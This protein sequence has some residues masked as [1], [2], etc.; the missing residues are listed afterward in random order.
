MLSLGSGFRITQK[1]PVGIAPALPLLGLVMQFDTETGVTD[2][3]GTVTAWADQATAS[4]DLVA[5]GTP[6]LVTNTLNG[7]S[8]ISFDGVGDSLIRTASVTGL[9]SGNANRTM[10]SVVK[11]DS[12]GYGGAAYGVGDNDQAFGLAVSS[13][14]ALVLQLWGP[15]DAP[16]S[17]GNGVGWLIQSAVLSG[18]DYWH[19]KDGVLNNSGT[20]GVSPNT[21]P[22]NIRMGVEIDGSP[23]VQMQLAEVLLYDTAFALGERRQ[24]DAYLR[25]KYFP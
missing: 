17:V 21:V 8:V 3:L 11:Y 24:V 13:L 20:F 12:D 7:H 22:N 14:G 6:S 10:F 15:Q 19:Y 5:T 1:Q 9:P 25:L 18:D 16:G 4:N 2:N 23:F